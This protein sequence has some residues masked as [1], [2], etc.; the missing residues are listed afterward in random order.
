MN[1]TTCCNVFFYL[2]VSRSTSL[3]SLATGSTAPV[4]EENTSLMSI[5]L[6]SSIWTQ[7]PTTV[8]ECLS[9]H[10]MDIRSLATSYDILIC[11]PQNC[12][13]IRYDQLI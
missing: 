5:D 10:G 12:S 4:S 11:Q 8:G 13:S 1:L 6:V 9:L 7:V 2:A 3:S